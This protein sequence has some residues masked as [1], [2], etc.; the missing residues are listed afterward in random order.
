M[1]GGRPQ[2]AGG[3][4]SGRAPT[5]ASLDEERFE[6][7]LETWRREHDLARRRVEHADT[8]ASTLMAVA[9]TAVVA[10]AAL[11]GP[12]VDSLSGG[13]IAGALVGLLSVGVAAGIAQLVRIGFH[14]G[15]TVRRRLKRRGL[16]IPSE[17]LDRYAG[18]EVIDD[19]DWSSPYW[20]DA[21]V[22]LERQR[23]LFWGAVAKGKEKWLL[24]A[25]ALFLGGGVFV[26]AG[27]WSR[28]A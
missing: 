17:V 4:P 18:D 16:E 10:A 15:P 26:A 3:T 14:R 5:P 1:T 7:T 6:P 22:R 12:T 28:W 19:F 20:R 8:Q 24:I 25:L 2:Q 23:A 21:L 9:V 11:I 27:A 13:A